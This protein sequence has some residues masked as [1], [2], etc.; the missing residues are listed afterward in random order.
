[1]HR[2][3][4]LGAARRHA[5]ERSQSLQENVGGFL[6]DHGVHVCMCAR[7]FRVISTSGSCVTIAYDTTVAFHRIQAEVSMVVLLGMLQNAHGSFHRIQ[8][9]VS[10]CFRFEWGQ[11]TQPSRLNELV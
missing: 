6:E 10:A 3:L 1:M 7:W 2:R 11:M 8:T 5:A 9:H 4:A